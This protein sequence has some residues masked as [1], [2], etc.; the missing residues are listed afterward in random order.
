MKDPQ[1]EEEQGPS[2]KED[3]VEEIPCLAKEK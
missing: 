2:P 3:L 1:N